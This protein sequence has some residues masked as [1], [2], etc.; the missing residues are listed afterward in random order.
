MTLR[1]KATSA[2]V[3]A[4][5]PLTAKPRR[6]SGLGAEGTNPT[7]AL[8]QCGL[9]IRVCPRPQAFLCASVPLW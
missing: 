3:R 5:G 9:P 2:T 1:S 4:M 8:G 6:G 7:A